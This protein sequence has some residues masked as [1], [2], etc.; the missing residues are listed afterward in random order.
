M[1][2]QVYNL[3]VYNPPAHLW[4]VMLITNSGVSR[5]FETHLEMLGIISGG[6]RALFRL[7]PPGKIWK[8]RLQG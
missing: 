2:V 3:H 8:E 5:E 1:K 4:N 7:K 6:V